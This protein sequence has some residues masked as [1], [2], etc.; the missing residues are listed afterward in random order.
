MLQPGLTQPSHKANLVGGGN[1]PATF[2]ILQASITGGLRHSDPEWCQVPPLSEGFSH[3]LNPWG[4]FFF[5]LLSLK[6]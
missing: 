3:P 4:A 6:H 2:N 5:L 1:D